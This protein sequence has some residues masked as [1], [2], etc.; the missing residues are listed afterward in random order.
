MALALSSTAGKRLLAAAVLLAC[1][2]CVAAPRPWQEGVRGA[3]QAFARPPQ[4]ILA[5]AH[6]GLSRFLG[7]IGELWSATDEVERLRQENQELREALAR[8]TDEAYQANVRLRSFSLFGEF[9]Q[10]APEARF[11]TLPASVLGVDASPWR[12]T[13]VVDRGSADGVR[14]GTPAVWGKSI[15]GL[16][17][18]VRGSAARVRLLH[19]GLAGLKVRIAGTDYIGLLR[20]DGGRDGVLRLKWLHLYRPKPGDQVITSGQ[21][22]VIPRGLVAGQIVEVSEARD[23]LFYDVKVRPLIDLDRLTEV[24]LVVCPP[25]DAEEL[26]SEKEAR[27][28]R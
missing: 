28:A 14:E 1:T 12:R 13:I 2:L 3:A 21:D 4:R 5:D 17:V 18:A 9:R 8:A 7:R 20:G 10:E 16:V 6:N 19:D 25:S 26:L 27:P 11:R 15:V 22:V 24:L 23:H